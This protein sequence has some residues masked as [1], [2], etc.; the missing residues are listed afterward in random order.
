M[1]EMI[2]AGLAALSPGV[3]RPCQDEAEALERVFRAMVM[4]SPDFPL[5]DGQYEP[6]GTI[7][8]RH[9]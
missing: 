1:D 6:Q 5:L 8:S 4:L 7:V 9:G 2:S 3:L